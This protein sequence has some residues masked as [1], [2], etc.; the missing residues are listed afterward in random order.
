MQGSRQRLV[1]NIDAG[2]HIR[3]TDR[4]R[5]LVYHTAHP[6]SEGLSQF[7]LAQ[8]ALED[9]SARH[10]D[11]CSVFKTAATQNVDRAR[12]KRTVV[13]V[14]RVVHGDVDPQVELEL[15]EKAGRAELG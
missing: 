1:V 11:L 8:V 7:Q 4:A 2:Y 9:V 14:A 10:V 3:S 15:L 5:R 6:S 13:V 12:Y